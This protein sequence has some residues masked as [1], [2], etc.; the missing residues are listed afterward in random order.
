MNSRKMT[1]EKTNVI[2]FGGGIVGSLLALILAENGMRVVLIEKK[3][4][5]DLSSDYYDGRSYALNAGT[6]NLLTFLDIWDEIREKVQTV[7]KVLLQ[8]GLETS[9]P[10][11]LELKLSNY[12]IGA[13]S[14]FHMVEDRFLKNVILKKIKKSTNI[15]HLTSKIVKSQRVEGSLIEITLNDGFI[16]KSEI[17]I[18]ADGFPSRSAT[19]AKLRSSGW[20]YNQSSIVGVVRHENNHE[21]QAIQFFLPAGPLAILPLTGNRSCYVWTMDTKE[22]KL[23]NKLDGEQ[24]LEKLTEVFNNFRGKL[25][26]DTPKSI[27]PLSLAMARSLVKERFALVGDSAHNI[28][29]I[30]GQGLN[31][32]IRDVACLSEVLILAS[33]NGED[34]GGAVVLGRYS[35]WRHSDILALS[36][37]TDVTNK[38]FSNDNAILQISRGLA[39]NLINRSPIIKRYLM[40]EASGSI[41]EVPKLLEGKEI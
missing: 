27:F 26:L 38:I 25:T 21:N 32:G 33:R 4:L 5:E 34:I 23:L 20:N 3:S 18:G 22:A 13:S 14:I 15:T 24:F 6:K 7:S 39:F 16:L 17:A 31:L 35:K 40:K 1:Q 19:R 28:H 12:D 11:P 8:Q 9:R 30:A 10:Q 36:L 37:F 2:I 29:P 41:G